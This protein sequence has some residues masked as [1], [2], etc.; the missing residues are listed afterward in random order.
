MA[1]ENSAVGLARKMPWQRFGFYGRL[2]VVIG[3]RTRDSQFLNSYSLYPYVLY[4]KYSRIVVFSTPGY[5]LAGSGP[6]IWYT[7]Y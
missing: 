4:S 6:L 2:E 3:S 1:V 5:I 7:M